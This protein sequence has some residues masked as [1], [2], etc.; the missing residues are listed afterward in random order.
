VARSLARAS[1][2]AGRGGSRLIAA[3]FVLV[4]LVAF[5]VAHVVL[6]VSLAKKALWRAPIALFV[7]PLAPYW[8]WTHGM[9]MRVIAWGVTVVLYAIGVAI[10]SR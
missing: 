10:A 3:V 1:R 2:A 5:F 8:G 4:C 6:V 7:V 9:R